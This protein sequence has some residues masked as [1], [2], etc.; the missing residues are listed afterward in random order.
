MAILPFSG[1]AE[2]DLVEGD[3]EMYLHEQPDSR[4]GLLENTAVI[5]AR[6]P[7]KS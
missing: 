2:F 6:K 4:L 7:L 5:P 1:C 3:S